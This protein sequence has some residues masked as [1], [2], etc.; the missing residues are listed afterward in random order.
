[1]RSARL[2]TRIVI[3]L[4]ALLVAAGLVALGRATVGTGAARD[5]GYAAG[6]TDGE[7]DGIR[8]GRALTATQSLPPDAQAAARDA[9][10]AGYTAG[11]NDAF[12]GYDGGWDMAAPYVVVLGPAGSGVT[13]RIESRTELREGVDYY[14][15]PPARTLCQQ[16]RR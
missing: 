3:V 2:W 16:P 1:M 4:A 15:C 10:G 12:N 8:V 13:Y 11:A 14:L 6:R 9:Y 7:A 5:R